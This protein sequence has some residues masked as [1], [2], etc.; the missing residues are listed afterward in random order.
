MAEPLRARCFRLLEG[1]SGAGGTS[2]LGRA[3]ARSIL[4]LVA[5]GS[6]SAVLLTEPRLAGLHPWLKAAAGLAMLVFAVEYGLRLWMAPERGHG[7]AI[8]DATLRWRY[9]TSPIGLIDL[10]AWAGPLACWLLDVDP[11]WTR[12]VELTWLLKLGRYTTALGLV[13]AVLSAERRPLLGAL[14]VMLIVMVLGA[15][16]IHALEHAAQPAVFGSIPQSMWWAV[17]TMATV[18]YGDIVPVTP[19]GKAFASVMLLIGIAMFA[20][21]AGIMASGFAAEIRRRDFV[22]TWQLVA[23]VPLF[24]SLDAA[25]IAE[26]ARLLKPEVVPANYVIVR[27]GEPAEA[28]FFIAQGTV[29]IDVQPNPVRLGRGQ[30]FGEIALLRDTV[31]TATVTAVEECQLLSLDI[32]DFRHLLETHPDLKATLE[33]VAQERR[34]AEATRPAPASPPSA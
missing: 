2:P 33:R 22:V 31:R 26:I 13:F 3:I 15:G 29:E 24:Q 5:L 6:L 7:Q 12:A 8:A 27:R 21:P 28:M 11:D 18:G 14:S 34:P 9:A 23:K 32:G 1:D 10:L 25:R 30:F 20:V 19:A 17:V 4:V 16:I